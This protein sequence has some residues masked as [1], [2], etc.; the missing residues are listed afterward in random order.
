MK[1]NLDAI[2]LDRIHEE[3]NGSVSGNTLRT[4][5]EVRKRC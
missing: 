5:M 2:G 4:E 1:K 3:G